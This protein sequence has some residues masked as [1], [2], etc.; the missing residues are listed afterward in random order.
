[1]IIFVPVPRLGSMSIPEV[2][3]TDGSSNPVWVEVPCYDDFAPGF[4]PSL[5]TLRM[6]MDR[7][8]AIAAQRWA[9]VFR[10]Y[11]TIV[12][13]LTSI[14][15]IAAG[16]IPL[17]SILFPHIWLLSILF[18]LVAV[19]MSWRALAQ[20]HERRLRLRLPTL[21]YLS[22]GGIMIA[23]VPGPVAGQ[24]LQTNP[25]ISLIPQ[26]ADAEFR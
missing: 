9:R 8:S 23:N 5:R 20:R 10:L 17:L 25:F 13:P 14:L 22:E 16:T 15:L 19:G 3:I 18:I 11:K 7:N 12:W 21:P 24:W 6:P 1:M 2:A 26:A 4:R